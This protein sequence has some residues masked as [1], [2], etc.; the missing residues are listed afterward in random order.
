[1]FLIVL[2]VLLLVLAVVGNDPFEH[3]EELSQD[4]YEWLLNTGNILTQEFKGSDQGTNLIKG[5]CKD[6]EKGVVNFEVSFANLAQREEQFRELKSRSYET[7][8]AATFRQALEHDLYVPIEARSLSTQE[9][10][11][12]NKE[13]H[14]KSGPS[15][16][17]KYENRLLVKAIV[18]GASPA[19][20]ANGERLVPSPGRTGTVNL[21]VIPGDDLFALEGMLKDKG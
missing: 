13:P 16:T 17:Q 18:S 8:S 3:T 14:D 2:V 5:K 15:Y 20:A 9:R 7:V 12:L 6:P 4:R 21:D 11:L 1:S 19:G 10:R